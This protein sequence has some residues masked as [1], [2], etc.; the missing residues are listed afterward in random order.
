M[1]PLLL[2]THGGIPSASRQPS[3]PLTEVI[4]KKVHKMVDKAVEPSVPP[5]RRGGGGKGL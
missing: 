5:A 1:P 3:V 2:R 4:H